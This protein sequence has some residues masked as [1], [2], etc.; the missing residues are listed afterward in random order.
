MRAPFA[1]ICG[2][3]LPLVATIPLV[4]QAPLTRVAATSLTL[5]ATPPATAY[6]VVNAFPGLT[7]TQPVAAVSP[8]GDTRRLFVV[9]KP[10]RIWLIP[11]VTAATP[12]QSLFLDL[13]SRVT[14]STSLSDERGLLALAFHP[15]FA[16]NGTFFVWYTTTT[17]T[18]AG[19]GLHDRLAR[20]RVTS[21][22]PNT[23]DLASEVPLIS[24]R[25]EASN[26]NGGQILFGPDGY[27]YLSLGDEGASDDAYQNSQ[28]IDRDFFSGILRLDVDQR[29]GSLAPQPHPSVHAGTYRIP[30][31]N[32][33]VGATQFNGITVTPAAVRTEFWA[34]GLRNPW[35][36]AF[37]P[38]TGQLWCGDVGQ[39][40]LEEVNVIVRGGN[41]GWNYREGTSAGPRSNPPAAASFLG[42]IWNY[43]R[44]LGQSITGGVVSR[45]SRLASLYGHYLFADFGSGRVWALRPDGTQPVTADRVQQVA[46]LAGVSSFGVDPSNGD[47]LLVNLND[48]SIRRLVPAATT[49]GTPFPATLTATGAFS[50]VTELTPAPG[51]VAYEPVVSFWSDHARKRRWFALTDTTS[52]YGFSAAGN[53][54]LPTGAVWVKHFDLEMTRGNPAT[55]R[56]VETRFLVKTATG[57]YGLSYRW[58]EAQTET[59]LV[60]EEGADQAFTV[61]EN[62]VARTQTWHFPSRGECQVCHTPAAGHALGF[63]TRQL[64]R[65]PAAPGGATPLLTA[66]AQAGYLDVTSLPDLATLP[67]LTATTDTTASL[68]LR[69]RSYLDAN[70]SSCHQPAGPALGF[71]DAR[72]ATPLAQAGLINGALVG[73]AD[74]ATR[75]IVPGDPAHSR[76]LQ[77]LAAAGAERMPPVATR[78]RDLAGETLL[79]DWILSLAAPA[80]PARLLNLSARASVGT[81]GDLLITGFVVSGT[82]SKSLLLRAVGP[83]LAAFSV[84]GPLARPT[85][86]LLQDGRILQQNTRWNTAPDAAALRSAA[87]QV[88]AFA[89]AEGSSDSALLASVTPGSYTAHLRGLDASTGVGLVE[90]YDLDPDRDAAIPGP[91]LTNLSVRAVVGAGENLLIP[92]LVVG[93]GTT[94][95]VLVR[96]VGPGLAAFGVTG[97]LPDP[98]LELYR[99]TERIAANTR[100]HTA[101]NAAALRSA[102]VQVGAF[103]LAEGGA[104]SA[105]LATLTPGAYTVQVRGA[106]GATGVALVEVYDLP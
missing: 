78:E 73:T 100:W 65:G 63:S 90:V 82:G 54:S 40:A 38:A 70:C 11:D 32:P 67:R 96:A 43:S 10:G 75:V 104:D 84:A 89:L 80:A 30:P 49:G 26:H 94:R 71:W 42:P 48:G 39:G 92:G 79:T 46:T 4:A 83:G 68:E 13:T 47:V 8:P 69:A 1:L 60:G 106:G 98:A 105:L 34:V 18:T 55:A 85:L 25:D 7:F 28:R 20:F 52:R 50:S 27:L 44:S 3:S 59:N 91:R 6:S 31:D 29:A 9:E 5:S 81:G 36:M 21:G 15:D 77:R 88:G 58:N 23:G 17:T 76:L 37:D 62:G 87:L 24:Q 22:N 12:T 97:V 61:Q 102:A 14:V 93:A 95:T 53:W 56:R 86:S 103:A 51:L 35:R 57:T 33:F 72:A 66:L 2:L 74:P 64:N 41:Y 16:N 19:G 45:G 101:T 99:G